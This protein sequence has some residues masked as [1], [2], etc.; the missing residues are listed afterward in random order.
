MA[1]LL[2]FHQD[3]IRDILESNGTLNH[4]KAR[5]RADVFAAL[6][7]VHPF[8]TRSFFCR[9]DTLL[10]QDEEASRPT[11]PAENA[12]INEIIREYSSPLPPLTNAL[13]FSWC[14]SSQIPRIQRPVPHAGCSLLRGG[15][16]QTGARP[17][18]RPKPTQVSF[19]CS[20]CFA[21]LIVL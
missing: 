16:A 15:H 21:F 7:V 19:S 13:F 17:R 5:L 14:N 3:V 12:L 18:I 9:C 6:Q 4:V 2:T 8:K 10:T 1:V 11:P 20:L